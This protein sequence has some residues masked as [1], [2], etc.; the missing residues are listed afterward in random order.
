[1]DSRVNDNINFT[2]AFPPQKRKTFHTILVV[3]KKSF[4]SVHF[5]ETFISLVND[6]KE[7]TYLT[8]R[9]LKFRSW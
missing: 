7:D 5:L 4:F 3:V 2:L 6:F 8:D 1:M 9:A